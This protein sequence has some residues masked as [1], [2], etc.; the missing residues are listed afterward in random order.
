[1]GVLGQLGATA[2]S[3][4]ITTMS[5]EFPMLTIAKQMEI[6]ITTAA[7][8]F[9]CKTFFTTNFELDDTKSGALCTES[10]YF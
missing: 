8:P 1:M 6:D 4:E 3:T 2:F 10:K 7:D 5:L 9:D